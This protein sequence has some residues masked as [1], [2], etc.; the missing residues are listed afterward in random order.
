MPLS[1]EI[2]FMTQKRNLIALF[3]M[4]LALISNAQTP[5]S[6]VITA[7]HCNAYFKQ[8][9]DVTIRVYSSDLG[10]T[11]LAAAVQK[12]EFFKDDIKLGET[13]SSNLNTYTYVWTNVPLGTY[14]ITAKATDRNNRTFT[15]AG[16]IITVGSD[17]TI[18]CGISA[19]KG[20]YLA[21]I[22][23]YNRADY[24][25]FWNGVTA[26]NSCKWG[27]LES[28]RDVMN[29]TNA[30][31]AYNFATDNHLCFRYHVLAW[32]S[33]YPSWITT[34][35][36]ADFQ[37]EMEELMAAVSERFT[38]IDQIDVLNE[39]LHAPATAYFPTGLGGPGVTGYDWIIWLYTKARYYF[40]NSKLIINEY[41]L[42]T[43][44]TTRTKM[45]SIV[46]LLRDRSLID[47][48][49]IQAHSFCLDGIS[50][51]VLQSA[52]NSMAT[53]GIP[54][55]I[56]ELDLKGTTISE[57]NQLSSY[58]S[59]FP[60]LWN[61]PAVAGITLW[62]YVE[63]ATWA[64]GTGIINS[65]NTERAAMTWLKSYINGL[66]N[67]GYPCKDLNTNTSA[68]IGQL[69]LN[70][71]ISIYPNPVIDGKAS[72][73]NRYGENINCIEIIDTQGRTLKAFNTNDSITKLVVS[74]L[75][76]GIYFMKIYTEKSVL[77]QKIIIGNV[78]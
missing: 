7:P 6:C 17:S 16:V 4:L 10:G 58:K 38:M 46:K 70:Q 23:G 11:Y 2:I 64:T 33:Q 66:P 29:W 50:A 14:R 19:G 37:A 78:F 43:D 15:S 8:G 68:G 54:L 39:C 48:I 13:S 1:G 65:D 22:N 25:S 26:E 69:T 20:K 44:A 36:P 27:I 74:D 47:G 31:K 45:L 24:T 3:L 76:N 56:T 35:S 53:T 41:G 59:L 21:N 75:N 62:G 63:G 71:Q 42:E 60:V 5:P 72:I 18:S 28:T 30:D 57:A 77:S 67:V 12:V 73:V 9:T 52:L 32:D 61:H 55:Y 51:T 49:G 34:L 40:P